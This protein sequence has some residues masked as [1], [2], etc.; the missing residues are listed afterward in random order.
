MNRIRIGMAITV[1]IGATYA[2]AGLFDSLRHF[3]IGVVVACLGVIGH[4]LLDFIE[5]RRDEKLRRYRVEVWRRRELES[6][7]VAAPN[8]YQVRR[9]G[10]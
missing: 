8:V 6:Q 4:G 1:I 10:L 3:A 9:D 7:P 2:A 5:S